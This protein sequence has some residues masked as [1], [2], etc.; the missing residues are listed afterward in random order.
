MDACIV[1]TLFNDVGYSF[2]MYQQPASG[3]FLRAYF[4]TG[5]AFF[6]FFFKSSRS[7]VLQL[8]VGAHPG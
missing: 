4:F 5:F 2:K 8:R 1:K 3:F 7:R 6:G